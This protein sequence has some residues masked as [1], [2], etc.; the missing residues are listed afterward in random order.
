MCMVG[1]PRDER[2]GMAR[3]LRRDMSSDVR[4]NKG[5]SVKRCQLRIHRG[6]VRICD[7]RR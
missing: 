2:I 1:V 6:T 5:M 3:G 7:M 4:G